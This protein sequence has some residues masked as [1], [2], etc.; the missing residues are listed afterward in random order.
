MRVACLSAPQLALQAVLRR[1]PERRHEAVAL[2]DGPGERARVV[3]FTAAARAAG[4]RRGLTVN[5]ARA[6]AA[7]RGVPLE[8]VVASAAD[9]A[10]AEAALADVGYAFAPRVDAEP[11]RVFFEV[12]D[13]GGLYPFGERAIAQAIAAHTTRVGLAARVGIASSKGLA[14]V[15]TRSFDLAVIPRGEE[16]AF[17][18]PLPVRTACLDDGPESDELVARLRRWGV[19]NLGDLARLPLAEVLL[20][21]GKPGGRLRRL[22]DAV[23]DEPFAPRLPADALEEG[24]DL[25]WALSEL[26]PL[27]FVLR[28][29]IDRSL[30]RLACRGLACAGLTMRLALETRAFD[31]RQVPIA[32]PTREAAPLLQLARLDLARRP[33]DAAVIGVTLLALPA[34]VRAEQLDFLRPSGPAPER[35]AATLAR[36]AALVGMDNVGTPEEVDTHREEAVRVAPWRRTVRPPTA[37]ASLPSNSLGLTIRRFQPPQRLEVIMGRDGPAALRGTETTARVLVAAGPYRTSGE[38]WQDGDGFSRDYWDVHASDGAVYRMHQD[39]TDGGW[40]LDGYYD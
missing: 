5:Q 18:A 29:L 9:T 13:L 17:L 35:M 28:G 6:A 20:R 30:A 8:V 24:T 38:W 3:G 39:K 32:A 31:V 23:D 16:R 33:P 27:A 15:A 12:G 21:L 14:R 2:G 40:Y 1:T 36:L 25:E 4:I 37:A 26:E 22:A 7:G 34:R 11:G 19:H 10:A